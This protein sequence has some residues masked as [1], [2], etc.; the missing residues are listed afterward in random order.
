MDARTS[1]VNGR[2]TDYYLGLHYDLHVR[3]SDVGVG[4]Q[5]NATELVRQL[6]RAGIGFVQADCKGSDGLVSYHSRLPQSAIGSGLDRD[7]LA[8]WCAAARQ[9]NIPI[10][11]H[12]TAITDPAA[13][14]SHPE[15][16]VAAAA[17]SP[18]DAVQVQNQASTPSGKMCL[19]GGYVDGLMIP[20][21]LEL[22]DRYDVNGF[23][24]DADMWAIEP[25]YCQRCCAAFA[26]QTGI[27]KPPTDP[28][29]PEW[30]QWIAFTRAS[31]ETYVSHYVNAVHRHRPGVRVCSNWMQTFNHP[32]EPTTPT[33]WISGD[34][35][36]SGGL[37]N[38][39]CEARFISTRGKPWDLMFW[40]SYW[41][42]EMF[43]PTTPW[44]FKSVPMM[45]QELG[46][47]LALG[48][49][50]M[51]YMYA[52]PM[53]N[54]ALLDW[55]IERVAEVGRF[56]RERQ[57]WCQES[58]TV[59]HIAILHSER[60]WRDTWQATGILWGGDTAPTRGAAY[61]LLDS[62]FPVDILDE[63]ALIPVL[64]SFPALVIGEQPRLSDAMVTAARQYV[65]A[66]GRLLLVGA[67]ML[68][69]FGAD[70][71]GA[72]AGHRDPAGTRYVPV[73]DGSVPIHSSAWL[74]L[75]PSSAR[76]V[77]AFRPL[78]TEG[79]PDAPP[80]YVVNHIGKGTVTFVPFDLFRSYEKCRYPM[81]R[82]LIADIADAAFGEL[83]VRVEAPRG[84]DVV[85]RR[86][87]G[88]VVVHLLNR[89]C[90]TPGR[91]TDTSVDDIPSIGPVRVHVLLPHPPEQVSLH[92]EEAA[93]TWSSL[94]ADTGGVHVDI[95]V[96]SVRLHAALV[97]TQAA[98][99]TPCPET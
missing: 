98:R 71:V 69:R 29:Q 39:R 60:H 55:Q 53:R 61:G 27:V 59:P 73:S 6:R 40:T 74:H 7:L 12:Y 48:G 3:P 21:L 5:A 78:P 47:V 16:R 34:C 10:H 57:A 65:Q 75:R 72:T 43:D 24:V 30:A 22:I 99:S 66:G 20:Q 63:W 42:G 8:V 52:G 88:C 49:H 77:G 68:D 18:A 26:A 76:P 37:D 64:A 23:W 38:T 54:G 50:V 80:A 92:F 89:T 91:P 67:A 97:L 45:C 95:V 11:C 83:P 32:G 79:G 85:V 35:A 94:A 90:G 87:D 15:W 81:Q 33:D 17:A 14:Q 4:A 25:C 46:S 84:V 9:L 19:R 93:I 96:A 70:F 28:Q 2:Q 41:A 62:Q 31:F 1:I 36:A 58:C 51:L 82:Q 44:A 56:V 86:K 13:A